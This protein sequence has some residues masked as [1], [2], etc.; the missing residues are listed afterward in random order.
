MSLRDTILS[1]ADRCDGEEA[2]G[3]AEPIMV[4][5]SRDGAGMVRTEVWSA[6]PVDVLV[7]A[8][9]GV[10]EALASGQTDEVGN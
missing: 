3:G 7:D 1:F 10:V 8:L 4:L 9:R 5:I 2:L 6:L